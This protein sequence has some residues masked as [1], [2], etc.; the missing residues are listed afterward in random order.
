LSG[1]GV[2]FVAMMVAGLLWFGFDYMEQE[3]GGEEFR[4][5]WVIVV[6]YTLFGKTGILIAG[7]LVAL[8]VMLGS[9]LRYWSVRARNR[10]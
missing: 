7:I 8:L 5:H 1:L 3:H 9:V 10:E 6:I 2:A 4:A